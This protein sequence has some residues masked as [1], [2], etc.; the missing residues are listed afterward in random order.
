[1][2]TELRAALRRSQSTLIGDAAGAAAIMTILFVG[3]HLPRFI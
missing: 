3:L 1:M 2:I